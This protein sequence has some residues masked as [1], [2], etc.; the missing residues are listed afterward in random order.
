VK[1]VFPI[2]VAF[3]AILA[4][5]GFA[6]HQWGADSRILNVDPRDPSSNGLR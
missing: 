4:L 1:T 5:L 6:A 3:V 2:I